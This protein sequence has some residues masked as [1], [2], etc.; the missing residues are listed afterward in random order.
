[1]APTR[2]PS[3]KPALGA[4]A[5][6]EALEMLTSAM[7]YLASADPTQMV[8]EEQARCLATIEEVDAVETAARASVLGGFIAGKGYCDDAVSSQAACSS[9]RV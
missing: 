5:I 8:I 1:L 7:S 2:A 9:R 4:W 3:A 6:R